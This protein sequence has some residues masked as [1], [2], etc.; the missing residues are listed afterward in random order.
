[1]TKSSLVSLGLVVGL[2]LGT[3]F[4][5]KLPFAIFISLVSVLAL[6][7]LLNIRSRDK[8]APIEVELL[9]YIIVIFF[10]MNNYNSFFDFYLFDYRLIAALILIDLIPL[11]LVN[12][13]YKYSLVDALYLM[14]STLFIGITFNL[15]LQFRSYNINYVSYIFLVAFLTD[16]FGLIAGRL[17]G[18]HK[19]ISISPKKTVEGALCGLAMGTIIPTLFY[20]STVNSRLP[21]YGVFL[22]TMMLSFL[23][24]IGDLVFSFIKREFSKKD[25]SNLIV[26]NGG[27]LDVFDS[28]IFVTLGFLIFLSIL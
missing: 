6:R 15:I 26:G 20:M 24:Q 18:S 19:L 27:I 7:E 3:L 8:H 13:K 5:D 1:M 17:I 12:N 28:I 16:I 11:V 23:A 10:T 22:I 4:L 21:I 25:F 9:S 14:G 2:F